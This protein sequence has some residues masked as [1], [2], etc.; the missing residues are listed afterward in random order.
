M[1][2]GSER[3]MEIILWLA[4]IVLHELGHY[5]AFRL[6]GYRPVFNLRWF[7]IQIG[8]NCLPACTL[9]EIYFISFAG[10]FMGVIPF[11]LY[12]GYSAG[13]DWNANLPP[14]QAIDTLVYIMMCGFDLTTALTAIT[15]IFKL[16]ST[17]I[18]LWKANLLDAQDMAHEFGWELK[19]AKK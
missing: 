17:R 18:R 9:L 3:T 15:W 10:V 4:V 7:G 2:N 5:G 16:K 14:A 6:Y 1:R 19:E 12:Q 13:W 11:V 8:S